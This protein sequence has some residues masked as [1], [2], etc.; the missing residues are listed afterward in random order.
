MNHT[1][2]FIQSYINYNIS[3]YSKLQLARNIIMAIRLTS[4]K[5]TYIPTNL[6]SRTYE[7]C[8]ETK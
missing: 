8:F 3:V 7:R 2:S 1:Y 5:L 4:F 6:H